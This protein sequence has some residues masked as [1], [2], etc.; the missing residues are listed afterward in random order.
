MPKP[1]QKKRC[2]AT[3]KMSEADFR[4][5][6]IAAGMEGISRQELLVRAIREYISNHAKE[7]IGDLK[8]LVDN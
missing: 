5:F 8:K 7:L 4:L 3:G 2:I 6:G 1:K